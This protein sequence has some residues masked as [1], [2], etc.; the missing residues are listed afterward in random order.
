MTKC[1]I[2]CDFHTH[3]GFSDDCDFPLEEMLSGAIAAGVKTLAV[4]DHHDPGYPDPEFPFRLDFPAYHAAIDA[5]REKYEGVLDIRKG[6]EMGIWAGFLDE[7]DHYVS[8]YDYDVVI[9]SF[10]CNRKDDLYRYDF[11]SS[12]GPYELEDFYKYVYECLSEYRNFDIMGHFSIIDRYIGKLY[13]YGP[14][15]D[16]IDEILKL[17]VGDGKILEINTSSFKYGTGT[18]MPRESVLRRYLELGGEAVTFGSDAHD[19]AYYQDHFGDA[20]EFAKSL[21]FKYYCTFKERKPDFHR[22]P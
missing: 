17:L 11:A 8:S 20:V 6:I 10:H 3:T 1:I 12:D 21:G 14:V 7:A 5:A 2:D 19:P 18:W 15:T 16:L 22:L 9:G 13:D 4:T